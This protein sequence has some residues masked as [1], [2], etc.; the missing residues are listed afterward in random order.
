MELKC[1]P[2][3][4]NDE[5][6]LE[7]FLPQSS[8]IEIDVISIDGKIVKKLVNNES[9]SEGNHKILWTV[10][11]D[12]LTDGMYFI[13]FITKNEHFYKKLIYKT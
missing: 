8:R 4:F 3:P 5:L 7:F 1:F 9:F 2:N 10:K 12:N 6:H 13:H 11:N